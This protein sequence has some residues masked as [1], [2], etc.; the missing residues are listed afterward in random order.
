MA[1]KRLV[2]IN[3]STFNQLISNS[4]ILSS[5]NLADNGQN[6]H[7]GTAIPL[8]LLYRLQRYTVPLFVLAV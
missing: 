7:M 3:T 8:I 1:L 2:S 4:V 6:F 5:L